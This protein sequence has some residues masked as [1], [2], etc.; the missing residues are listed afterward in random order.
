MPSEG[1]QDTGYMSKRN[2]GEAIPSGFLTTGRYPTLANAVHK[3]YD[4]GYIELKE[5]HEFAL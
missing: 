2:T 4:Y 5:A 3:P 1:S